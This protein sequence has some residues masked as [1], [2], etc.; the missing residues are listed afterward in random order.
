MK[1]IFFFFEVQECPTEKVEKPFSRLEARNISNS[2][3]PEKVISSFS[4]HTLSVS[5]KTL[6]C[7]G[8]WFAS[9]PKKIDYADL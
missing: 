5:E 6:P 7:K 3:H 2:H 9:P 8:L 1:N 4:S